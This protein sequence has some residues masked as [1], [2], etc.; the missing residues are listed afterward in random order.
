MDF[1]V[2]IRTFKQCIRSIIGQYE[3]FISG[4]KDLR[5]SFTRK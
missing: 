5:K 3:N 2:K 1:M 4:G